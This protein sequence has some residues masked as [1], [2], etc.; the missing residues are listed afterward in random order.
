MTKTKDL[1]WYNPVPHDEWYAG[2][3][4]Q[5]EGQ[6][7]RLGKM[8]WLLNAKLVPW[9]QEHGKDYAEIDGKVVEIELGKNYEPAAY[10][11]RPRHSKYHATPVRVDN[12]GAVSADGIA[13]V[14]G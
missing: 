13:Y 8:E 6:A 10:T 7:R 3:E 12:V 5:A 14:K 11:H 2:D 9:I 1:L 4:T